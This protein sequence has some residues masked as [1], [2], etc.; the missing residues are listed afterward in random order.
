[1]N[2]GG[3]SEHGTGSDVVEYRMSPVFAARL[4]GLGL[5]V[6]ALVVF[7]YTAAAFAF[8]WPA[9][10]IV[11]LVIVTVV[12][13]FALGNW[14]RT[15]AYVVRLDDAGYRVRFVR[16]VGVAQGTWDEVAEASAQHPH[17]IACLVM[18]RKDGTTTSIPVEM[19]AAD[20]DQF[21]DDVIARLKRAHRRGA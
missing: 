17:G 21:A 13:V 4:V 16:G 8:D 12:G 20:R 3:V 19:L 2:N 10:V 7:G 11:V 5:V 14:L 1:M 15:R 9:D 6:T 18:E